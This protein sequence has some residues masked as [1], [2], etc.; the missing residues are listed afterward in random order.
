M[1]ITS[2]PRLELMAALIGARL[3]AYIADNHNFKI[4]EQFFWTD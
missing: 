2:V 4:N 3:A 1:R